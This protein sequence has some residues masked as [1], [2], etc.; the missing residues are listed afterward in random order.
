METTR[1]SQRIWSGIVS[2]PNKTIDL[3]K[4]NGQQTIGACPRAM[5]A[6]DGAGFA[7]PVLAIRIPS[8]RQGQ[9]STE[10]PTRRQESSW[11]G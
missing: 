2:T 3:Q 7:M 9:G 1:N 5:T 6:N 8:A 10:Y 11:E 4:R